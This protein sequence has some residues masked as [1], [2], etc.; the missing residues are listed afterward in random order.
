MRDGFSAILSTAPLAALSP[1]VG[2]SPSYQ[3]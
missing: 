2:R 3:S 1:F